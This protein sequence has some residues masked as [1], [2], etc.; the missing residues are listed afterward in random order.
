MIVALTARDLDAS[1]AF[2]AKYAEIAVVRAVFH[3]RRLSSREPAAITDLRAPLP[4]R[5]VGIVTAI[6]SG[7]FASMP[8][9]PQLLAGEPANEL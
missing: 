3:A 2:Y 8:G 1:I 9:T 7:S 4:V 5:A 6:G